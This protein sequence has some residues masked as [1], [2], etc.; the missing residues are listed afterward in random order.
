MNSYAQTNIQLYGQL[1]EANWADADLRRVHAAYG[2]AMKIF[3]GHFRP[4]RKPFLS[5]LVGVGS[6]L[7]T[8]GGEASVVAA[9]MLHSAYSHGEFG[10]GGRGM[11]SAKRQEVR[12]DRHRC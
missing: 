8:H 3:A 5:H 1:F 9:G 2:L 6:I 11:T 4:N 10:D 12:R 7:A